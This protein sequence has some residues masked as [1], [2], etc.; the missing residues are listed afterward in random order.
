MKHFTKLFAAIFRGIHSHLGAA[1]LHIFRSE[2]FKS[3][4]NNDT[5]DKLGLF[6]TLK[7]AT[8]ILALLFL[9]KKAY[10]SVAYANFSMLK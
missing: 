6:G 5:F 2:T 10:F 1:L 9:L 8:L 7:L 4:T 3:T